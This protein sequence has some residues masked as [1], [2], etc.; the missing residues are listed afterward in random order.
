M[1][2]ISNKIY[3]NIVYNLALKA[4]KSVDSLIETKVGTFATN[5]KIRKCSRPNQGAAYYE[6][7]W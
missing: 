2:R 3:F 7:W 4:N 1:T 5:K 6:R